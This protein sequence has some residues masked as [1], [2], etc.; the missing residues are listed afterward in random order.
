MPTRLTDRCWL[1]ELRGVNA[2]LVEDLP[3]GVD[4]AHEATDDEYVLTLV[5]AG[6]PL[7]AGRLKRAVR[8]TGHTLAE[9]ERVLVTHYDVDH[10]GALS[11]LDLDATVY[12]GDP[13]AD[14]LAGRDRPPVRAHKGA[15]QRA[16]SPLLSSPGLTI[17]R[18]ADG[19]EVGSFTAYHTPGHTQG[20]MAY[21]SEALSL[22]F[23][24]DLVMEKDG[25]LHPSPWVLS[26]DTDAVRESIHDLADREPAV[27]VLG[28]GH[29]VPFLR[30]GSVRLARLGQ[31]IE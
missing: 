11:R 14:Y 3:D 5:D 28:M 24:G 4:D 23:V 9:I 17:E 29:G 8:E 13:D 15:L 1:V 19:D 10:V 30:D 21:V 7:D 31:A 25:D 26:Y 12:M 27:E 2:Y 22:A 16:L 20:H 6:T 18:V